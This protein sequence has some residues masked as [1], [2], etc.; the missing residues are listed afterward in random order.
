M[1]QSKKRMTGK[2]T[3]ADKVIK[4]FVSAQSP[5]LQLK[6]VIQCIHDQPGIEYH[7][8][9]QIIGLTNYQA[10]RLIKKLLSHKVI[11]MI[12]SN[13]QKYFFLTALGE[14][15]SNVCEIIAQ[16]LTEELYQTM[17]SYCH[18]AVYC[19]E[20]CETCDRYDEQLEIIIDSI[21]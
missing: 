10:W 12:K 5:E 9:L 14:S 7:D 4:D 13:K 19:N 1:K 2:T 16:E 8:L 3:T 17:C 20:E 11:T 21:K 6:I 18:N 15:A